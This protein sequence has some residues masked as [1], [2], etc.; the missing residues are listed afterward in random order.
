MRLRV[1]IELPAVGLSGL[2][3]AVFRDDEEEEEEEGEEEEG[4]VLHTCTTGTFPVCPVA[5]RAPEEESA[6]QVMSS[7]WPANM[8]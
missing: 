4:D 2:E 5:A 1:Q 8:V 7:S 6:M 3:I